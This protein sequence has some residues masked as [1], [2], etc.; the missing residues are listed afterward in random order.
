[1]P[2]STDPAEPSESHP[3]IVWDPSP[4]FRTNPLDPA[5]L[6][7]RNVEES[8]PEPEPG[9]GV[10]PPERRRPGRDGDLGLGF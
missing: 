6:Q 5:V 3:A 4:G 7:G 9:H 10:P 8:T 2:E 1:V